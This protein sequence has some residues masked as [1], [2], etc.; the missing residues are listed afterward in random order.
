MSSKISNEMKSACVLA[1][2][3]ELPNVKLLERML[4][5]KGFEHILSTQDPR[6]V[7]SLVR[8]NDVD[9]ILLD[10]N[11]PHMDGYQVME[12]LKSEIPDNLPPILVL[13]AQH[14]Q[15]FRQRA[16]DDGARDY[17]TKPFDAD[18]LFSRVKNLLEVHQANKYMSQ[19]NAILD[20]RVR[21]RTEALEL[22]HERL[23]DSRLQVVR[24][25]GR[26]AEYRDNETGL[27]IIRMS[28]MAA[29]IAKA[30][31]M[32]DA[33][34]DLLLNAA[35]MHDIGKIGIPD[36]VLL[37]PGKLEAD[38]W[39]IMKTHAQI[40][41][42]ILAG[43]E[44]PLLKMASEIA[45]THHEKWDGSGYP[46]GLKAENIPLVGR[47]TALADVFDALT[48]ER[49]Y[50]KAWSVEDAVAL[51][52]EEKGKHFDPDLVDHFLNILSSMVDIKTEYAE[53]GSGAETH[54]SSVS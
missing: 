27:H 29:L 2:D 24:R 44:S 1:V 53:P 42:D 5:A 38:E 39:A 17:V 25:L 51:I 33:E 21:Q 14:A 26:A 3:D 7:L 41:A 12:Q 48:S 8:D 45:L 35:P 15:D 9:L 40:G 10:I 36:Q 28:K 20:E 34:C 54:L 37:K 23:H 22:A 16:L 46:N 52:K 19:Q 50:K 31:G 43:D 6:Q 30:V 47:I 13:T 11:M 32:T 4:S 18:E 49:P